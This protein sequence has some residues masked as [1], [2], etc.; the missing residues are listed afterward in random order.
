MLT[1]GRLQDGF[2]LHLSTRESG[3]P[4]SMVFKWSQPCIRVQMHLQMAE[5]RKK[6]RIYIM[7]LGEKTLCMVSTIHSCVR[8]GYALECQTLTTPKKIPA[9]SRLSPSRLHSVFP[10]ANIS[11]LIN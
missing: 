1:V 3:V 4:A 10:N 5:I 9:A 8:E 7:A 2:G 11:R 6:T